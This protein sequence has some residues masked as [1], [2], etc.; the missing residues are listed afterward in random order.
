[1]NTETKQQK[2][3]ETK[4]TKTKK[5]IMK[6]LFKHMDKKTRDEYKDARTHIANDQQWTPADLFIRQYKNN[7]SVGFGMIQ[8]VNVYEFL[9]KHKSELID[10]N[11][12]SKDGIN[13]LGLE[14]W[15]DYDFVVSQ[16][17]MICN[18]LLERRNS[19]ILHDIM[20]GGG[21]W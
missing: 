14:L 3:M 11:L 15:K 4:T 9:C 13:N 20:H 10:L 5:Q 21:G 1:M 2:T 8:V 16:E 7:L 12:V 19:R 17:R 6:F 18:R